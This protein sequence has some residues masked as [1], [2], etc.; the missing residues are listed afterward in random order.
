[1]NENMKNNTEEKSQRTQLL[2]INIMLTIVNAAIIVA[3]SLIVDLQYHMG[4]IS[5][6][7]IVL[8]VFSCAGIFAALN[9]PKQ[10]K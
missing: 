8:S 1:M 7:V 9:E 6:M 2:I 10:E 4:P 5:I 3:T